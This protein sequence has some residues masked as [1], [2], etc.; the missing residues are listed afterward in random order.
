[1][2]KNA[3]DQNFG[4]RHFLNCRTNDLQFNSHVLQHF[5]YGRRK[6]RANC[7]A[8]DLLVYHSNFSLQISCENWRS[9]WRSGVVFQATKPPKTRITT[10]FFWNLS[11]QRLHCWEYNRQ[12]FITLHITSNPLFC[13]V[14]RTS[15]YFVFIQ[16][17]SKI[18]VKLLS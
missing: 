1:M 5:R 6:R 12:Q 14:S 2:Y 3:G 11:V 16:F 9:S 15:Y 10:G 17:K 4:H 7:T 18:V 8:L 13:L